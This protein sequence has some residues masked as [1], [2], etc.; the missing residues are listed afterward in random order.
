[1]YLTVVVTQISLSRV[2]DNQNQNST[3]RFTVRLILLLIRQQFTLLK[4]SVIQI[5]VNSSGLC[6]SFTHLKSIMKTFLKYIWL[7]RNTT[8]FILKI[9]TLFLDSVHSEWCKRTEHLLHERVW[10]SWSYSQNVAVLEEKEAGLTGMSWICMTI[11]QKTMLLLRYCSFIA[12][13]LS[14]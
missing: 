1:M 10:R 12:Q 11:T 6:H 2:L 8:E 3:A 5:Q 13:E 9:I 7:W 4:P 14:S